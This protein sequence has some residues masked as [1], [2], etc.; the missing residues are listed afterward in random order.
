M[1]L[2]HRRLCCYSVTETRN[3]PPELCLAPTNA[4][5]ENG[6]VQENTRL[7]VRPLAAAITTIASPS[8]STEKEEQRTREGKEEAR[9]GT[10]EQPHH[11]YRT[12][13][14]RLF[15]GK[16]GKGRSR[17]PVAAGYTR[18]CAGGPR[19]ELDKY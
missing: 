16:G 19:A 5:D 11:H 9:E 18:A 12:L 1:L 10:R 2:E 14:P 8:A 17:L 7:H 3:T 15:V 13:P 6:G 4:S